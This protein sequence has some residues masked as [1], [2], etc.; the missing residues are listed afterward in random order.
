MFDE[1]HQKHVTS[2]IIDLRYNGGGNSTL[3]RQIMYYLQGVPDRLKG[4]VEG[5]KFSPLMQDQYPGMF[6]QE[7][8]RYEEHYGKDMLTL[9]KYVGD[10]SAYKD[11]PSPEDRIY[12]RTQF[13]Q[14][15]EA[16]D[17]RFAMF[18]MTPPNPRFSGDVFLLIGPGTF[19]AASDFATEMHDNQLAT[20]VGQSISQKPTSFGD[21]LYFHL[22]H[23]HI[24]GTVSYK[25]CY[26]PDATKDDD[27]TLYPDVEVWPMIDDILNGNDPVFDKVLE[28][29]ESKEG[30]VMSN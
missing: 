26:R 18:Y 20:L 21:N 5:I 13:F 30:E 1:I 8:Q 9:P 22:P 15:I 16:H 24:E 3:G 28:L 29:I 17:S 14:K 12:R 19:S 2:L 4:Y 7:K 11:V 10:M 27:P 23:T 6:E 25:M